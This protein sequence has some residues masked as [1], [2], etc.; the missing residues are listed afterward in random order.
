MLILFSMPFFLSKTLF[1]VDLMKFH[2]ETITVN[3]FFFQK[4]NLNF[5]NPYGYF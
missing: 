1:L 2:Y 5:K 3:N 4:V